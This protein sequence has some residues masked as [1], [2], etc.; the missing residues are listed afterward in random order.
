MVLKAGLNMVSPVLFFT[1]STSKNSD[2]KHF[3]ANFAAGFIKKSL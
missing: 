1:K 3:L 2:L